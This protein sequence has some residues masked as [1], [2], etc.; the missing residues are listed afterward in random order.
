MDLWWT[1]AM[2][3]GKLSYSGIAIYASIAIEMIICV[4]WLNP[5]L[6]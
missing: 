2:P 4:S 1:L 6:S 5:D 3:W